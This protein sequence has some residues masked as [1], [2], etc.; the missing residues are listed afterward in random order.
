MRQL[1]VKPRQAFTVKSDASKK[2]TI[3]IGD[4]SCVLNN[5]NDRTGPGKGRKDLH[6]S[7]LKKIV[8]QFNLVDAYVLY[9]GEAF[10][11]TWAGNNTQARRP[12]VC[13][14]VTT[15]IGHRLPSV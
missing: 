12:R 1:K 7:E 10:H 2:G 11:Y 8:H 5:L 4:F 14:I 15:A 13:D 9:H 3:L 6:S